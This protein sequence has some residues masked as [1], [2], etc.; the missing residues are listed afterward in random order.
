MKFVLAQLRRSASATLVVLAALLL[1]APALVLAQATGGGTQVEGESRDFRTT[2]NGR[3][4][5][6]STWQVYRSGVWIPATREVGVPNGA[7]NVFIETNHTISATRAQTTAVDNNGSQAWAFVEVNNLHINTAASITTTFGSV[8]E[9]AFL[10]D[11]AGNNLD[12]YDGDG[13]SQ[14]A[15]LANSA[16]D[17]FRPSIGSVSTALSIFTPGGGTGAAQNPG[18]TTGGYIF[19]RIGNQDVYSAPNLLLEPSAGNVATPRNMELRVYGKLRYYA[20]AAF[21]KTDRN[22]NIQVTAAT[23]GTGSTIVFR[24]I[25]RVI[26]QTDEW[27]TTLATQTGRFD[28][29]LTGRALQG[30]AGIPAFANRNGEPVERQN[31]LRGLMGR[32]SFWTAIFDL[33]RVVDRSF[34][35]DQFTGPTDDPS[36]AIGRLRGNFTAG[37]I[38]V[39]RGTVRFEGEALLANEGAA[40]S[41]SIQIMNNAVLQ[42]ASGNIGRT[43]VNL[44]QFSGAYNGT[45]LLSAPTAAG[46]PA[47]G[48]N[49]FSVTDNTAPTTVSFAQTPS[50]V[51]PVTS[52]MRYFVVEEGGALDFVGV[53]GSLSANDVRFN[54][55]VIYSRTGDQTLVGDSPY[56]SFNPHGP[57]VALAGASS[58]NS[59]ENGLFDPYNN[60]YNANPGSANNYPGDPRPGVI[61]DFGTAPAGLGVG[62]AALFQPSTTAAYSHLVIRGNGTKFLIATTVTISRALI[63]QGEATLALQNVS[64][65]G[66]AYTIANNFSNGVPYY[67]QQPTGGELGA[68][69]GSGAGFGGNTSRAGFF[70][71][72]VYLRG[73]GLNGFRQ[74]NNIGTTFRGTLS[75]ANTNTEADGDPASGAQAQTMWSVYGGNTDPVIF[76]G[77][78][79]ASTRPIFYDQDMY[80]E[81]QSYPIGMVL[82]G[83][84]NREQIDMSPWNKPGVVH[85]LPA[86]PT[87]DG[88]ATTIGDGHGYAFRGYSYFSVNRSQTLD[89]IRTGQVIRQTVDRV[90]GTGSP[91]ATP[92]VGVNNVVGVNGGNIVRSFPMITNSIHDYAINTTATTTLQY[93]TELGDVMTQIE[94]PSGVTGPH[95][96]VI[97]PA[98]NVQLNLPIRTADYTRYSRTFT[99]V[100]WNNVAHLNWLNKGS[101]NFGA[102]AGTVVLGPEYVNSTNANLPRNAISPTTG[103]YQ[104][105]AVYNQGT[106]GAQITPGAL[107][108]AY[109]DTRPDNA[110]VDTKI[111]DRYYTTGRGLRPSVTLTGTFDGRVR[112]GFPTQRVVGP[113]F[114]ASG[115]AA[116]VLS[117]WNST[118]PPQLGQ[119]ALGLFQDFGR[120]GDYNNFG[121]VELRRGKLSMRGGEEVI[122]N[123][124][125]AGTPIAARFN[126]SF[127]L[128][129]AAIIS[130]EQANVTYLGTQ[131]GRAN[132]AAQVVLS[133]ATGAERYPSFPSASWAGWGV[134]NASANPNATTPAVVRGPAGP[135]NLAGIFDGGSFSNIIFTGGTGGTIDGNF[136]ASA[137]N[138]GGTLSN[139]TGAANATFTS[140]LGPQPVHYAAT[141]NDNSGLTELS[142]SMGIIGLQALAPSYSPSIAGVPTSAKLANNFTDRYNAG[143]EMTSDAD[144][145][146]T[147]IAYTLDGVSNQT[148]LQTGTQS[149]NNQV[150]PPATTNASGFSVNAQNTSSSYNAGIVRANNAWNIDLPYIHGGVQHLT[151]LRATSNVMTLIGNLEA[152]T[153]NPGTV[154]ANLTTFKPELS[155]LQVYGT[156]ATARGDIDLNGRN[157]EL[158]GNNSM[159]VETFERTQYVDSI[160][161]RPRWNANQVGM[162]RAFTNGSVNGITPGTWSNGVVTTPYRT[163]DPLPVYPTRPSSVINN[164]RNVRAYIGLTSGRNVQQMNQNLGINQQQEEP[165]GLGAEIYQTANPAQFRVRRWQTRGNGLNGALSTRPGVRTADRYWQVETTGTMEVL[166]ARS[167]IRLQYIDTDLNN[168]NGTTPGLPP[169]SLNMFRAQGQPLIAASSPFLGPFQALFAQQLVGLDSYNFAKQLTITGHQQVVNGATVLNTGNFATGDPEAGRLPDANNPQNPQ[170]GFQIWAI[171]IPAPRCLVLRGQRFGGSFG[172]RPGSG[173]GAAG[174]TD[175]VGFPRPFGSFTLDAPGG[176]ISAAT[177]DQYGSIIGPFKAG[178]ATSATIIADLLDEFGNVATTNFSTGAS[179]VVGQIGT[180]LDRNDPANAANILRGVVATQGPW[181]TGVP[182]LWQGLSSV[183]SGR[184]GALAGNGGVTANAGTGGPVGGRFEWPN[185]RLDGIASTTITF[186]LEND[187]VGNASQLPA[188]TLPRLDN[189]I[190]TGDAGEG[191]SFFVPRDN[192]TS[193]IT[194]CDNQPVQVSLQGGFPFS[195]TFATQNANLTGATNLYPGAPGPFAAPGRVAAD[196]NVNNPG[197][198]G[199][200]PTNLTGIPTNGVVVGETVSFPYA[201]PGFGSIT[202]IV[203][204]RFGNFSSFPTTATIAIAGGSP[205]VDQRTTPLVGQTAIS[206]VV[207]GLGNLGLE[208]ATAPALAA[209]GIAR[210]YGAGGDGLTQAPTLP[211]TQ[212]NPPSLPTGTSLLTSRASLVSPAIGPTGSG[213]APFNNPQV[214][215]HTASF[216]NFQIWGATSSNVTLVVSA[217]NL[218]PN[219]LIGLG[220]AP[221][222]T[223]ATI[224]IVPSTAVGIAPVLMADIYNQNRLDRMPSRMYIGRSNASDPRTWFYV[225]AVDQFGNRVDNGPRRYDGGVAT[226]T[227][228]AP[229]LGLPGSADP[230]F[231]FTT[232]PVDPYVKANNQVYTATGLTATAVAGLFTYRD[233]TPTGN[234]SLDPMGRDVVLTFQDPAL[235]GMN[236]PLSSGAIGLFRP[237]PPITTATTTFLPVPTVSFSIPTGME[238][239]APANGATTLGTNILVLE[240]RARTYVSGNNTLE[241]GSLRVSRPATQVA[242]DITVAYTASY[243]N[244]TNALGG[245]DPNSI[246]IANR[247]NLL[248]LPDVGPAPARNLPAP[249]PTGVVTNPPFPAPTAVLINGLQGDLSPTTRP[250]GRTQTTVNVTTTPG[251]FFLDANVPAQLINFTARYSDQEWPRNPGRQGVRLAIFR[252]LDPDALNSTI[253]QVDKTGGRDSGFVALL[254]PTPASPVII[255]AIQDKQ[256]LRATGTTPTEDRIELESPNWRN[257]FSAPGFVFY[258]DN[259]DPMTYTVT[260]SDP[261]K[262]SVQVR[263]LDATVVGGATN[264]RPTLYYAV[265]PGAAVGD[266]VTI[267][268]VANDGTARDAAAQRSA[269][270]Q[271]IIQIRSSVTS[272]AVDPAAIGFSVSPNPTADFF[273]VQAQAQKAGTVSIKVVNMLGQV[274]NTINLPVGAGEV[275]RR[276]VNISNLPTGAYS[277]QINDGVNSSTRTV[278]K[279]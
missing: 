102:T 127:V 227:F 70:P 226:I 108:T 202:V 87:Y 5:D 237:I 55:T 27:S 115:Q 181:N 138:G 248:S 65:D 111:N 130:Y 49:T 84:L 224:H 125:S 20:G 205:P 193:T 68:T 217:Q 57:V 214:A 253:Y 149:G 201:T 113:T 159:L 219:T 158:G 267:T 265:Q 178:F 47:W 100:N 279:N 19:N 4:S 85:G 195:V 23:I 104:A 186:S 16:A 39:R 216:P 38:Q 222:N 241:S 228:R 92:S 66:A 21:D 191:S 129:S 256:L 144:I 8:R 48:A 119:Q 41:G 72:L 177:A 60:N 251:T 35:V 18:G 174:G 69:S 208:T 26:T 118:A 96:L 112:A 173:F 128:S 164:H 210:V 31:N 95:N 12:R 81:G 230:A 172:D 77:F 247:A 182:Q 89:G 30:D 175:I 80:P 67:L 9:N 131:V 275:Y 242:N 10:Y 86:E 166:M 33:G 141:A 168:E 121:V 94:F 170:A 54:G 82:S 17:A 43:A 36:T 135:D 126:S 3:W 148:G 107:A 117:G 250:E 44:R 171:G 234:A 221:G 169:A 13:T 58:L 56:L 200:I 199:S 271:F 79:T 189:Q 278:I 238:V 15:A 233:F 52:R 62:T 37:I 1:A 187:F 276:D 245:T 90:N 257:D 206:S 194:Y 50:G 132:A 22:A 160:G 139:A 252:L 229:A 46:L 133:E 97:N 146:L 78:T 236:Q 176:G 255:N 184:I 204:D 109:I 147:N 137:R 59:G 269:T 140:G 263:P 24:G 110:I 134:R 101:V 249:L 268:V 157:I 29:T 76:V 74:E 211:A 99:G 197:Y 154:S 42:M 198:D 152:N 105:S 266:E 143:P 114:G 88:T 155:G 34:S 213:Y 32:N 235:R 246:V 106:I 165:G 11:A 203:K 136:L 153:N 243:F 274:V 258:D 116:Y 272:V 120:R 264:P 244:A 83:S 53:V 254:D 209:P 93:D 25:T 183:A 215:S 150:F 2:R 63:F 188:S 122:A 273:T 40:T 231:Q 277:V 98:S 232:P 6:L 73:T 225:Q 123:V 261:T 103:L 162:P 7:T 28:N 167:E 75:T 91:M 14:R 64:G 207:W 240:E 192:N 220:N 218:D 180:T 151:F 51:F 212:V 45:A 259:Y 145:T 239:G 190:T 223:S 185:V 156:I 262:V 196:R 61:S 260:S 161:G 179:L 71:A 124:G 142:V 270:D 163:G